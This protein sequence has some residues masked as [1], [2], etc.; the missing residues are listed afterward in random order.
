MLENGQTYMI[1][2][3]GTLGKPEDVERYARAARE[4]KERAIGQLV[5]RAPYIDPKGKTKTEYLE[6][7]RRALEQAG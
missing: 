2:E 1:L 3:D 6:E 7:L 4:E 5:E